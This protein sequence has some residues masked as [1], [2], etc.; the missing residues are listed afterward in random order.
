MSLPL[1][2]DGVSSKIRVLGS[3]AGLAVSA[4]LAA[5]TM[6]PAQAVAER[7]APKLS[8]PVKAMVGDKQT[9][10]F[11]VQLRGPVTKDVYDAIA[12]AGATTTR[13]Y[14][15]LPM[16]AISAPGTVLPKLLALPAVKYISLDNAVHV[17]GPSAHPS[18]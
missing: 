10:V 8:P 9:H 18:D 4:L 17:A 16:T 13:R 6:H 12:A 14:K 1:P 2:L 15:N 7:E 3:F 11:I 5:W